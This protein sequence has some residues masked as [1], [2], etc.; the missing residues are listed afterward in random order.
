MEH[1]K[2]KSRLA[3]EFAR[4]AKAY[5]KA[6]KAL[7]AKMGGD[8]IGDVIKVLDDLKQTHDEC[9]ARRGGRFRRTS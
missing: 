8:V 7:R 3:D 5:S 4:A 6:A 9:E 1:C 2:E